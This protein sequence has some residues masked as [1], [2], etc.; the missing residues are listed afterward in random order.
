MDRKL[1]TPAELKL[2]A[3]GV[4]S[5]QRCEPCSHHRLLHRRRVHLFAPAKA[6]HRAGAV[7]HR[8]LPVCQAAAA[9]CRGRRTWMRERMRSVIQM[10]KGSS[11]FFFLC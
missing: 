11:S 7:A 3:Q 1:F 2:D 9:A 8:I 6:L 4:V 10:R 5:L